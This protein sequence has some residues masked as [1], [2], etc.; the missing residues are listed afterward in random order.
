[1][2]Y[3]MNLKDNWVSGFSTDFWL[4]DEMTKGC[5]CL[6]VRG[7]QHRV[8]ISPILR[9]IRLFIMSQ[10]MEGWESQQ[11]KLVPMS[12]RGR[13]TSKENPPRLL[14]LLVLLL[15]VCR[16]TGDW[17]LT[18]P[19]ETNDFQSLERRVI[20]RAIAARSNSQLG[21]QSFEFR[22]WSSP[23]HLTSL[24]S[25]P[26][27]LYSTKTTGKKMLVIWGMSG[28]GIYRT[29]LH[30]TLLLSYLNHCIEFITFQ[31]LPHEMNRLFKLL[32]L[33]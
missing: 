27:I 12:T 23:T 31:V 32:L 17:W 25:S 21:G 26:K 2:I 13:S 28:T 9:P 5:R 22:T 4:L 33:I 19:V 10:D 16:K 30:W 29:F 6:V 20:W 14:L 18:V 7:T 11:D 1:M 24:A 8:I 3:D 15:P